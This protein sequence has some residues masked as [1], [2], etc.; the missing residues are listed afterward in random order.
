[1]AEVAFDPMEFVR[2][3][4]ETGVSE[5]QA[6]AQAKFWARAFVTN[7]ENLVTKNYLDAR[8]RVVDARFRE[9]DKHIET[10]FLKQ[11]A[12]IEQR[13]ADQDARI[14]QRFS[15][16]DARIEQRFA[17]HD[18]RFS[19]LESDIRLMMWMLG[20]LVVSIVP[21]VLYNVYSMLLK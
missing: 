14:E 18:N 12:R 20:I 2:I 10:L 13:F 11:N 5:E 1:M 3:L 8:F 16:Q 15:G 19:G 7:M 9:Q 6:K 17:D 4:R 21:S